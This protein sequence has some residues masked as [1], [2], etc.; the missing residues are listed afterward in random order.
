MDPECPFCTW[1]PDRIWLA[2]ERAI[3]V[4]D[5]YPAAE[6]HCLVLPRAH[7]GSLWDL[8]LDEQLEVWNLVAEARDL[9][10]GRHAPDGFTVGVNDGLAAGQTIPHAH[11][12]VIPRHLGDVSDPTGGLRGILPHKARYWES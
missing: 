4:P 6:G 9:L 10:A 12:H 1:P 8:S 5:N 2:S 7:V 3:V 11:V